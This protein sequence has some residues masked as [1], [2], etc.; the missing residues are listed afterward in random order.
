MIKHNL[1]ENTFN[2]F[3]E[4]LSKLTKLA[5][6]NISKLKL[7]GARF[8]LC[9]VNDVFFFENI[10]HQKYNDFAAVWILLERSVSIDMLAGNIVYRATIDNLPDSGHFILLLKK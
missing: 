1:R 8:I 9:N 3:Y 5:K 7:N 10:I 4:A 6:G 2:K